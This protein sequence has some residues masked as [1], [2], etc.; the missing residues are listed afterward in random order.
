[1][2]TVQELPASDLA[3][4][5]DIA[6]NAYPGLKLN[7][8]DERRKLHERMLQAMADE[9]TT[10]MFGAY[11]DGRLV[12]GMRLFDFRLTLLSAKAS[13]GGVGFVAVDL[14]H[15]KEHV[16]K[17][18]ILAFLRHYRQQGA[19]IAMLYPFRPDF[20]RQMGFGF[21]SRLNQYRIPPGKLPRGRSKAHVRYAAPADAEQLLAC[22]TR[23]ADR[24]H[25]MI[26]RGPHFFPQTLANPEIK[27]LVFER[28]G[29][30]E[31]YFLGMFKAR[32]LDNNMLLNDLMINELVYE[33]SDAL[34]ELLTFLHTQADQLSA[35]VFNTQD[36]YFHQLVLDP[37]NGSDM[38]VQL[39]HETNTQ[40]VGLMYHVIDVP[41]VFAAL[42]EHDFGGQSCR[43]KLMLEDSFLPENAGST[44][45]LFEQGRAQVQDDDAHDVA[46]R[47]DVAD[48]SSLLVGAI[49]F[50]RLYS[51]GRVTLS[52]PRYV[53]LLQRLFAV[54]DKPI[55]LT[56][57]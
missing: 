24:T 50:K 35:I 14:L 1:M 17:E 42:R 12:G 8:P 9:P 26:E 7:P 38:I 41:G 44:T 18:L 25:G 11:R 54:E 29:R 51:Y 23:Y 56:R 45:I 37:R 52:D 20:Y 5:I 49:S 39:H 32:N 16:A 28:D 10:H 46:L 57:F 33:H 34:S 15:K 48:F 53:D 3:A 31:G 21:V 36:E 43:L 4:F 19:P 2:I 40:G 47:L 27:A 6:V 55:C 22:Y 13:A 30:I